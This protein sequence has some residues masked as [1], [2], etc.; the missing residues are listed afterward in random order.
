MVLRRS[1]EIPAGAKVLVVEDVVTTGGSV[2]EVIDIVE[3]AGAQVVGVTTLID[4]G[5]DR[6][7]DKP[8]FPLL[9]MNVESWD[10]SECVQ[11]KEGIEIDSPGSRRL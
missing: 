11:C 9:P 8:F 10:P 4:R 7:F 3:A 5:G 1:F 2:Q 6:A